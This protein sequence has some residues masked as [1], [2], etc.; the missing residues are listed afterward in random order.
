VLVEAIQRIDGRGS[1]PL[2]RGS[3]IGGLHFLRR[4]AT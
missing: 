4:G 2:P 3:A 1:V